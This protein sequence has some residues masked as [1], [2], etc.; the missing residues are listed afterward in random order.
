[1]ISGTINKRSLMRLVGVKIKEECSKK[2]MNTHNKRNVQPPIGTHQAWRQSS[3]VSWSTSIAASCCGMLF[4]L[5]MMRIIACG[6][7]GEEEGSAMGG[8]SAW[9]HLPQGTTLRSNICG[10]KAA[11]LL[12]LPWQWSQD[13]PAAGFAKSE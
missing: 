1:M 7:D 6:V 11:P 9:T 3:I 13:R 8:A 10:Q 4:L 5:A 12:W 2:N